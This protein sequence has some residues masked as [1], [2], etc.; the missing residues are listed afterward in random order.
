MYVKELLELINTNSAGGKPGIEM[1][2]NIN[3]VVYEN[4]MR[5]RTRLFAYRN[6]AGYE[7][8]GRYL[9]WQTEKGIAT[10]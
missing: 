3:Q 2:A 4:I 8:Q 6:V 5:I 10:K 7:A 1:P 9:L